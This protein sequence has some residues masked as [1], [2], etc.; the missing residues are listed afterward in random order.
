VCHY[1]TLRVKNK[2][3]SSQFTDFV[4]KQNCLIVSLFWKLG[5]SVGLDILKPTLI[6]VLKHLDPLLPHHP[7]VGERRWAT[8]QWGLDLFRS[9]SLGAILI[10]GFLSEY[11]QSSSVLS[12]YQLFK[13]ITKYKSAVDSTEL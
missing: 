3:V 9:S 5:W 8:G 1:C 4:T 12:G 13:D 6:R 10:F 11:Y 2:A 7:K